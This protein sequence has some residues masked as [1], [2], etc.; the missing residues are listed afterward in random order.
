V[1]GSA[2]SFLKKYLP[3]KLLR[4]AVLLWAEI[5]YALISGEYR[6]TNVYCPC[7]NKRFGHFKTLDI[8][9]I[10]H[11]YDFY[12]YTRLD[13]ICPYCWSW[14]RHR[15]LA[16][17][18]E[19]SENIMDTKVLIFALP[20]AYISYFQRKKKKYLSADYYNRMADVKADIQDLPFRDNE[21]DFISCDH[22]LEHVPD[23][24]KALSELRRIVK[25]DG[26]VALSVPIMSCLEKTYEDDS[27][28][29]PED[30]WREFGQADHLR[31]YGMDFIDKLRAVGFNVEIIDGF[32]LDVYIVPTM[33]A[34]EHDYNKLFVCR[35]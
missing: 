24:V 11:N 33:A 6:G 28:V 31:V 7:C 17:Y 22:V 3:K 18:L 32:T 16:D 13:V 4:K 8:D 14:S 34:P 10:N 23:D 30:R 20:R 27:V 2:K 26:I 25:P 21:F 1:I 5:K 12:R 29:S 15:V 35:K 19:K 9:P